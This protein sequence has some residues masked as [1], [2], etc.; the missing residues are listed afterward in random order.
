MQYWWVNQNQTYKKEVPGGFLWSPKAKA[1]GVR[2]QFY[3]HM[4]EV[5]T[6][7]IIFSFCDTRIK[8]V[9]IALGSAQTA[10]KPDFGKSG[11]NWSK[12]GWFILV[13]FKEFTNPIHPKT[14]IELIR[15]HLPAKYSPLQNSGDGLQ[16]V[17]L[18]KVPTQMAAVLIQLIGHEYT[19]A[20]PL[21]QDVA[22]F[23][24]TVVDKLE[25]G[26]RGRT[27][28]DSTTREQLV[29]SRRGQGVFRANVR[30]NENGCRITGVKD[31]THLR[32]SHI[33]PWKDSTD[34]E[35]L[36]GCNGLLL[37]PHVDHLF[38]IGKISFAD[39]G[40]LI[41][42]DKLDPDILLRWGIKTDLNVG[43]FNKEQAK[44]LAYHRRSVLKH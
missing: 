35:K 40:Q 30:L 25:Q 5:A 6:G 31:P 11:T 23:S 36:N 44:F 38:D 16:S 9:G 2:N 26:I 29:K 43:A 37:A 21:L 4:R 20:L 12:E 39:D 27:D 34:D 8:A 10:P 17:Y 3:E 42:S 14:H 33:K 15:P 32:A 18:A 28:I 41:I 24:E 1:D 13:E 19:S 7:D 22:N